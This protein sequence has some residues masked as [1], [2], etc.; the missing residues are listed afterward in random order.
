VFYHGSD[1]DS[2]ESIKKHGPKPSK[3]GSEGPGHYVTRDR[4]KAEKYAEFTSKQR[5]KTP[6]VVQYRVPDTKVQKV[7][8]IP[9]GLTKQVKTTT[10]HPVIQNVRTGH[11]VIDPDVA[12]RTMITNP[13]PII[14]KK[15]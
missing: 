12:K 1:K 14:K 2:V 6:A 4:K 8:D 7:S 10:T 3:E 9:K 13:P 15:R 11:A 5:G